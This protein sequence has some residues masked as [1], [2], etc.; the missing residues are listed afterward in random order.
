MT[1]RH[2]N[3][4]IRVLIVDDHPIVR[5]GLAMLFQQKA[6]LE[7]CGDADSLEAALQRIHQLKP[8]IAIVDISLKNSNGLDLIKQI[9]HMYPD[10][11]VLVLSVHD[12]SLYAERALRAGARG[13]IMK[14]ELTDNVVQA[15]H[16]I[17]SGKLYLSHRMSETLLDKLVAKPKDERSPIESFSDRELMVFQLLGKGHSTKEIADIL[18]VSPKTIQSYKSRIKEKLNIESSSA[19]LQLAFQ[20][21]SE[22]E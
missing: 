9:K 3:N 6:D 14:E 17:M 7:V 8:D 4:L 20:W 2:T 10:L 5:E 21:N 19:L 11:P 1:I 15:I 13:Y 12:E 18:F 22:Q 16:H